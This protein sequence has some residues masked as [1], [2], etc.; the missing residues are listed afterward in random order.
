MSTETGVF[1]QVISEQF[2]PSKYHD[3]RVLVMPHEFHCHYQ[4]AGLK[5]IL[6]EYEG[7]FFGPHQK[8]KLDPAV[9]SAPFITTLADI[10]GIVLYFSFTMLMFVYV[11]A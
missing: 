8:M 11:L 3:S 6:T 10:I 9:S 4:P 1:S 5:T 7:T 2:A